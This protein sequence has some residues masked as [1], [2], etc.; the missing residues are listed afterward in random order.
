MHF[1]CLCRFSVCCNEFQMPAPKNK[2]PDAEGGKGNVG[3][4][5]GGS[6]I[7]G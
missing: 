3:D 6:P 2:L 4:G 1:A 5:D 7:V